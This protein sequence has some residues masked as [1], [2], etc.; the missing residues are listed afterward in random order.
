MPSKYRAGWRWSA[1]SLSSAS[2]FLQQ[3]CGS[4][5]AAVGPGCGEAALILG[6]NWIFFAVFLGSPSHAASVPLPT[7]V[8]W[9]MGL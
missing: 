4:Q 2:L 7:R 3:S 9:G 6:I 5:A 1:G 8:L